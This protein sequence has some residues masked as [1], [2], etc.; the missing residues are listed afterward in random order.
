MSVPTMET[1]EQETQ[2]GPQAPQ[3]L[4]SFLEHL[5][6]N[7]VLTLGQAG[8]AAQW[9][10]DNASDKRTMAELLE[11][12]FGIN[13]DVVRQQIAQYYAFRVID[14]RDRSTRRL[15]FSDINRMLRSLPDSVT[16]QL[17]K[18]QLLPY[19]LAENQPDKI[20]LV[21][22]NPSDREIHKLARA[23]P[24]KKFEICYLK[25][26]DWNEYWR[27]LTAEREKPA[28]EKVVAAVTE[29][30]ES[31]FEGVMDRE[32]VRTQLNSKLDNI[33]ADA[34]RNGATEIHFVPQGAR[35]T[36]V[37]FRLEHRLSLWV[38][39]EDVRCEAV[40][41]A[42]KSS[43][44]NLDRYERLAV[45]Q[46][47]IHGMVEKRGLRLAV[48][49]V[50]VLSRD[51]GLRQES[52]VLH[53]MQE[54]EGVPSLDSIGLDPYAAEVLGVALSGGRGL[55]LFAGYNS[56]ALR[57]TIAASLKTIVK[58]ALNIVTVEETVEFLVD[59]VRQ[60]KLNP[61]LTLPD[62]LRAIAAHDP[63]VVVLGD[64]DDLAVASEALKMA[65]IGQLVLS[66]IHTRTG[67]TA[68]SRLYRVAGNGLLLGD[69]LTAVVAQQ[70]VRRL[71]PRCKQ[72][73]SQGTLPRA[74]AQLRLSEGESAPPA[75]YRAVGCIDCRGGYRG[76]KA[77][78]EAIPLTPEL[79]EILAESGE[80]LDTEMVM[81]AALRDGMVPLRKKALDLVGEGQTTIDQVLSFAV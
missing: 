54:T 52:V 17:L 46:G 75:I 53:V 72:P 14:P 63:D 77:L 22:P 24:F 26:G 4:A 15:L 7:Q 10:Q 8:K 33:F 43:G 60:I 13:R 80:H 71:C 57:A 76:E 50:P 31:D 58:P 36:D 39:M 12:E 35:K 5:V 23:L 38:S 62:A 29:S 21:S 3:M 73:V 6:K 32:I 74:I 25:E 47:F 42:L 64:I 2:G 67:V 49:S 68:L 18:A 34:L 44:I 70:T 79:R 66:S 81:K 41:T 59:G 65:N 40:V 19:D 9:K 61:H 69:A 16:Q 48:S 1:K 56:S 37:L 51:P 28:L 20:V 55:V 27:L 11:Q 30:S 78:F 45:Q